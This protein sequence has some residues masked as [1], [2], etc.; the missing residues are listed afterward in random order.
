MRG[1]NPILIP[2]N[3]RVEEA[4]QEAYAGDFSLFH[5]LVE[6]WREPYVEREEDADLEKAPT[7]EERVKQTFCGT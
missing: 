3:H 7:E 2:R 1:A 5:R 6:A 4:I